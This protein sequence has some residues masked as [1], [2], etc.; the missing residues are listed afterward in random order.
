MP[1]EL[2]IDPA[3]YEGK[4][5]LFDRTEVQRYVPHRLEFALLDG[6]LQLDRETKLAVGFYDAKPDAFW[7]RGHIPG[8]P[9][10]P[11]VLMVEAAAQLCTF[12]YQR[13]L[14]P[15]GEKR[16]MGFGGID[17]VRFRD[18]LAP[19]ARLLL[20]VRGDRVRE[21]SSL[22]TAQGFCAGRLVFEGKIFALAV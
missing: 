6:V 21:N 12:V 1:K 16:F 4:P 7:A 5:V 17:S 18:A 8:R 22:W 14:A 11:G 19:P 3:E 9:L 20:A 13:E 10:M 15:P 2:L